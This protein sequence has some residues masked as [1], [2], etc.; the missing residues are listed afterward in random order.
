MPFIVLLVCWHNTLSARRGGASG[1]RYTGELD[2]Q[3][4]ICTAH[5]AWN[6]ATPNAVAQHLSARQDILVAT[7][8]V[9]LDVSTAGSIAGSLKALR[10]GCTDQAVMEVVTLMATKPMKVESLNY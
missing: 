8:D 5:C 3:Q 1:G 7:Q 6:I 2:V 4:G 10:E 9:D